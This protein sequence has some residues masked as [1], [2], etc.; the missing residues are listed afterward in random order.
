MMQ[1]YEAVARE[2]DVLMAEKAALNSSGPRFVIGHRYAR[3]L[4]CA[5][6]EEIAFVALEYRARRFVLKMA[7]SERMI[8]EALARSRFPQTATQ[9]ERYIRTTPFFVKHARNADRFA[10]LRGISRT[11]LKVHALRIRVALGDAFNAAGLNLSPNRVLM[12]EHAGGQVG[13]CLHGTVAWEHTGVSDHGRADFRA[14]AVFN[15]RTRV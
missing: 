6:G 4:I 12:T 10:A 15:E 2:I 7:E 14:T 11:S 5:P 9:L 8:F 13:Y 1:N 3:D